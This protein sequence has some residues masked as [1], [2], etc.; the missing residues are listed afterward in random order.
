MSSQLKI[1]LLSLNVRGLRN[2]V[3]RRSIFSFLKDQKC[4][5]FLLQETF[6]EL[7][8]ELIWKSE[9]GGAIFFSHGSTHS[10]GVAILINP[11]R[12]LN[13][14]A[15]GKD[16]DGRIVS[17][18]LIYSSDRISICNVYAPNDCQQQQKFLLNLNRYLISNTEIS[19]LI[20]GGDWNVTLQAMDKKG[21]VPWRPTLYRDKLAVIMG[22]IG[23]ID[24]FRKL[25][26]NE[27]SF[28]YE[29]N[30]VE[31]ELRSSKIVWRL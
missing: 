4:D 27:R 5:I 24:V 15:T 22:D 7:K 25:N 12:T 19:N 29:E 14:E 20:V 26:P 16:L 18:D 13:I 21:G 8:D 2:Q 6:S 23:L 9:W 1:S 10:K 17:V 31:I 30:N 11:L 28:S 3:K